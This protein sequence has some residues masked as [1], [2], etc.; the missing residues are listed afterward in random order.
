MTTLVWIVVA[1]GILLALAFGGQLD[2]YAA[3]LL[4]FIVGLGWLSVAL[5]RR[6]KKGSVAPGECAECGGL[7][8]PQSP[9]CK[10]CGALRS[11]H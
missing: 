5:A 8:S 2:A 4:G 9:Y 1:G 6:M 7:V 11:A 3:V 10:H